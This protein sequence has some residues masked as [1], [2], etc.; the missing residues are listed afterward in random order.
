MATA[1]KEDANVVLAQDPDADRFS[2]AERRSVTISLV[3]SLRER[4]QR[5]V[6]RTARGPCSLAINSARYLRAMCSPCIGRQGSQ[7]VRF[8]PP[9]CDSG[10]VLMSKA[11]KLAMVASTVSSK[12]VEAIAA[13]EG[14]AFVECLTGMRH[15]T[16]ARLLNLITQPPLV[17]QAL[18]ISATPPWTSRRPAFMFRSDMK[19]RL[20]SCLETRSGTRTALLRRYDRWGL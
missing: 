3:H 10:E 12:M 20:G 15:I 5:G 4:A 13:K 2:A 6:A 19:R 17:L 16:W 1:E 8:L 11:D 18:N 14:F 7:S 9:Q